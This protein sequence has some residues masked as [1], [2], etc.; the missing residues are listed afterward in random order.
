MICLQKFDWPFHLEYLYTVAYGE[1][2]LAFIIY[3]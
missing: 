3:H 2:I 1:L